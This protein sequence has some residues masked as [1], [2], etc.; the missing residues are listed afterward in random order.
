M[1]EGRPEHAG[2]HGHD[3]GDHPGDR[4]DRDRWR[5]DEKHH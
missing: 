3:N 5:V 4:D 2:N 1:D